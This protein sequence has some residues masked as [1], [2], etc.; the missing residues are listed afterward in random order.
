[1]IPWYL[2]YLM[3]LAAILFFHTVKKHYIYKVQ[4][5]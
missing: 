2:G 1:M 5:K 4:N 3:G